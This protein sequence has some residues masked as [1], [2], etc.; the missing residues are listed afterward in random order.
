MTP[1][2]SDINF[3]RKHKV[4]EQENWKTG[5][6]MKDTWIAIIFFILAFILV[7]SFIVLHLGGFL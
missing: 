6:N 7:L 1:S 5:V 4:N 3:I 2:I